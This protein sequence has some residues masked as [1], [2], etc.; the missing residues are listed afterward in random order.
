[1]PRNFRNPTFRFTCSKPS[2]SPPASS[3]AS[4]RS[5]YRREQKRKLIAGISQQ[6]VISSAVQEYGHGFICYPNSLEPRL[7]MQE[8]TT[9][10]AKIS[11]GKVVK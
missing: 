8:M 4:R 1:M 11:G 9:E 7:F 3:G 10:L 6:I 5:R 2:Y